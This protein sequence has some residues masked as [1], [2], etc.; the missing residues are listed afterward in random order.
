MNGTKK[1]WECQKPIWKMKNFNLKKY[2]AEGRIYEGITLYK[3]MRNDRE[4]FSELHTDE[5]NS[6][7]EAQEFADDLAST[8]PDEDYWVQEYEPRKP[9][10]WETR[11][12]R[13]G[14]SGGID[15]HED[16]YP[17]YDE[18][19]YEEKTNEDV[20]DYYE[21]ST[22]IDNLKRMVKMLDKEAKYN[23][24]HIRKRMEMASA[25]IEAAIHE[26]EY[27]IDPIPPL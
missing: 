12:D 7:E 11:G 20:G 3:V 18:G 15:G 24:N 19:I 25:K 16:L 4:G 22:I 26:L 2:I 9:K 14:I 10:P 8:F 17:D 27:T 1:K 5:F 23:D 6:E 21:V 13:G